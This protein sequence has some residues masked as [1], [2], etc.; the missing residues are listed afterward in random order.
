MLDKLFILWEYNFRQCNYFLSIKIFNKILKYWWENEDVIYKMIFSYF[1]LWDYYSAV[2]NINYFY[3]KYW[4]D[5]KVF[6]IKNFILCDFGRYNDIVHNNEKLKLEEEFILSA[7]MYRNS[8]QYL[9]SL[10]ILQEWLLKFPKNSRILYNFALI[11]NILWKRKEA[12]F[13]SYKSFKIDNYIYSIDLFLRILHNLW[14]KNNKIDL[15]FQNLNINLNEYWNDYTCIWNIFYNLWNFEKAEIF[16]EKS[17][18]KTKYDYYAYNW[19]WN[20]YLTIWNLERAKIFYKYSLIINNKNTYCYNWLW[21]IFLEGKKY[22]YA[23]KFFIKSLSI[24]KN[25]FYSLK[26]LGIVYFQLWDIW[27]SLYFLKK[28]YLI[29]KEDKMLNRYIKKILSIV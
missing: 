3:R 16:Y 26:K 21:N 14:F 24:N 7:N 11:L 25:N 29:N 19:L 17:I 4:Y 12:L 15:F 9:H 18:K 13:F 27:K 10:K 8:W 23:I 20:L 1:Q 6:L 22:L 28:A 2:K 5:K